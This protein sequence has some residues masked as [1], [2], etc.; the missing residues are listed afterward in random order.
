MFL[1]K[2]IILFFL[3]YIFIIHKEN[4]TTLSPVCSKDKCEKTNSCKIHLSV[5]KQNKFYTLYWYSSTDT[6]I[7]KFNINVKDNNSTKNLVYINNDRSTH[8]F[9]KKIMIENNA[10]LTIT[11]PATAPATATENYSSNTVNINNTDGNNY[12]ASKYSKDIKHKIQCYPD[13]SFTYTADCIAQSLFPKTSISVDMKKRI[14]DIK[15]I[16]NT[17]VKYNVTFITKE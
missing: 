11:A 3:I 1:L 12:I 7:P 15:K 17:Y 5:L 16:L 6:Y 10:C 9:E 4:F 14:E 13:G 8:F 2:V